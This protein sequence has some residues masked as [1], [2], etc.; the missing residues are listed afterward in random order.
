MIRIRVGVWNRVIVFVKPL[1]CYVLSTLVA[2]EIINLSVL[3]SGNLLCN[4]ARA[5][6]MNIFDV[7]LFGSLN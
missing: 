1:L 3:N 2:S 6:I 5:Y 7:A 4:N